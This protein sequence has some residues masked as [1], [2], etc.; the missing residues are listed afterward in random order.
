MTAKDASAPSLRRLSFQ[1]A[2]WTMAGYGASQALRLASN[3]LLTRLLA[4]EHFGL[5]ALVSVFMIGL[6][7]FSDVG[8][9]PNVIQHERGRDPDFLNTAWTVQVIRGF[10]LSFIC[11]IAAWPF[12][13]FYGDPLLLGLIPVAGLACIVS[14]FNSTSIFT[15]NRELALGRLT[16]L[17]LASQGA[18]IALMLGLAQVYPSIWVL[19]AGALFAALVKMLGSHWWLPG[20]RNRLRWDKPTV[21]ALVKFGRWVFLTTM[22]SFFINSAASLILGKFMSMAD[23]GLFAIAATLAKAVENIYEQVSIRVLLPVYARIKSLSIEELR[24]RIFKIRLAI[25]FSFLPPLWIIVVFGQ[26]IIDLLF[27]ARYHDAGWMFRT[28]GAGLIPLVIAGIGPF[29]LA[30]GDSLLTFKLEGFKFVSFVAAISLG[31]WLAGANGIIV[32]LAAQNCLV[33]LANVY[34]QRMHAI[35]LWRI[36]AVAILASALALWAG[37]YFNP[38]SLGSQLL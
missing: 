15:L 17:E 12:A 8:I 9:G 3:L 28:Y 36:D 14:G 32:G 35:W 34:V 20:I 25:I 26:Q 16:L 2:A 7:M 1:G 38:L 6:A 23:L 29:Y 31:G 4:P 22:L 24:V 21:G 13:N 18:A 37:L 30:R 27:D 5:M 19:V 11:L 10:M 33:Y